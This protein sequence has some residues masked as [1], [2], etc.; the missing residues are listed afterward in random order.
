MVSFWSKIEVFYRSE[1][2]KGATTRKWILSIF[3]FRN[4]YYKLEKVDEKNGVICLV[5]IFPSWVMNL[6]LKAIYIYA[7]E[8]SWYA[9]SENG[10]VY[11]AMTYYFGEISV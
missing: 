1:G 4:E 10:I 9:L 8:R 2:T 5:T 7:S 6:S 11:C 3:K